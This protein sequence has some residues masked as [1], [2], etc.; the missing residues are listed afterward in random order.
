M[1]RMPDIRPKSIYGSYLVRYGTPDRTKNIKTLLRDAQEVTSS[2]SSCKALQPHLASASMETGSP[3]PSCSGVMNL[4]RGP[5]SDYT[6]HS[7]R[8]PTANEE[9]ETSGRNSLRLA[10]RSTTSMLLT[11]RQINSRSNVVTTKSPWDRDQFGFFML[12]PALI[13]GGH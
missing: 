2:S 8:A 3:R 11:L 9:Y 13:R 4:N 7:N 1:M 6:P 10:Q 12:H 5:R